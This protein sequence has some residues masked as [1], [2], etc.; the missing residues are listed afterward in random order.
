[1]GMI[2]NDKYHDPRCVFF[3]LVFVFTVLFSVIHLF[4]F[5]ND[6]KIGGNQSAWQQLMCKPTLYLVPC[7]ILLILIFIFIFEKKYTQEKYH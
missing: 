2:E 5:L 4:L 7:G 6:W 1:M 3:F